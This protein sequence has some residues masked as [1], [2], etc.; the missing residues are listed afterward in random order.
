MKRIVRFTL[1]FLAISSATAFGGILTIASE[2]LFNA[3]TGVVTAAAQTISPKYQTPHQQRE[4]K[5]AKEKAEREKKERER[6][7]SEAEAKKKRGQQKDA[8]DK[9]KRRLKRR[10]YQTVARNTVELGISWI[11]FIG[12]M[13]SLSAIAADIKQACDTLNELQDVELVSIDK[14]EEEKKNLYCGLT[15]K[16]IKEKLR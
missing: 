11:P 6:K 8:N 2:Q 13:A 12:Y 5:R 4:E 16:Q 10:A 15:S 1:L 7:N 9:L 14:N 3:L